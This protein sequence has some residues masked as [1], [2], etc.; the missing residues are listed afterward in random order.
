MAE[1]GDH[2][3]AAQ[4]QDHQRPEPQQVGPG[5]EGR[6]QQ[7]EVAV[8]GHQVVQDL[9]VAVARDQALADQ[10]PQVLGQ[11]G[12]GGVDV[13]VLADQA[14]QALGKLAGPGF[15]HRIVE[16][17]VGLD[18]EGRRPQDQEDQGQQPRDGLA[19]GRH[20]CSFSIIGRITPSRSV[21]C[22]GPMCW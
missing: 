15:Q 20:G 13:L 18:R 11:L 17:L 14:A 1:V 16:D 3:D 12:V 8:A 22:S 5:R 9:L 6:L 19:R 10:D 7:D 21:D 2:G 4:Q